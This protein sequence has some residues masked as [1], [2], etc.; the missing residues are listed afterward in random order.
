[1]RRPFGDAMDGTYLRLRLHDILS[2][3]LSRC[4]VSLR[5]RCP[6]RSSEDELNLSVVCLRRLVPSS[7]SE[8]R[9]LSLGERLW[10]GESSTCRTYRAC[11]CGRLSGL[12]PWAVPSQVKTRSYAYRALPEACLEIYLELVA[13]LLRMRVS[14]G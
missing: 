3:G 6:R 8:L 4:P 14:A 5:P 7:E 13:L 9:G 11:D 2:F 10:G 1:M 12:S